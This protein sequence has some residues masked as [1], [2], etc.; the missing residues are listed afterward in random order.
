MTITIKGKYIKLGQFLKKIQK[1]DSGGEAKKYISKHNIRIDKNNEVTRGSKIH[2]NSI[3]WIEDDVYKIQ[4]ED[5][6]EE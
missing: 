4:S 2:H 3:V 5:I 6:V 1:I